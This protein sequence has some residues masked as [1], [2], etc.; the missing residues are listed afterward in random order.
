MLIVY[1]GLVL[2]NLFVAAA[3]VFNQYANPIALA[4]IGWKCESF[5]F[6]ELADVAD[7]FSD[8]VVYDVWIFVELLVVYFLFVETGNLSLEQTAAVLDGVD[9]QATLMNGVK[10][11]ALESAPIGGKQS[12]G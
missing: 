5:Y 4:N 1:Q 6:L 12:E 2:Y 8:Y 3:L 9:I 10:I 7:C 11:E